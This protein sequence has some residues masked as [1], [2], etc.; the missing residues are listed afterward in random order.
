[1]SLIQKL[2]PSNFTA[3]SPKMAAIV[4]YILGVKWTDPEL[5]SLAITS[6]GYVVSDSLF[7]GSV[8]DLERNINE[9]LNVAGLTE[10]ELNDWHK[11]YRFLV[12]DWRRNKNEN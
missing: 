6:D 12:I 3:M 7:I 10:E 9:L 2:H 4:A 8:D 1:V 5:R 11:R